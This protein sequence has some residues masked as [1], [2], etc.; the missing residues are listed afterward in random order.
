MCGCHNVAK[1]NHAAAN[2]R[3]SGRPTELGR[4]GRELGESTAIEVGKVRL[5]ADVGAGKF[6][7]LRYRAGLSSVELHACIRSPSRQSGSRP[8]R[9]SQHN[10]GGRHWVLYQVSFAKSWHAQGL[11]AAVKGKA[12]VL[13]AAGCGVEGE[14]RTLGGGMPPPKCPTHAAAGPVCIMAVHGPHPPPHTPSPPQPHPPFPHHL[15]PHRH[16]CPSLVPPHLHVHQRAARV[17]GDVRH[18]HGNQHDLQTAGPTGTPLPRLYKE[19]DS[20]GAAPARQQGR[21]RAC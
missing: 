3:C 5:K 21:H 7:I 14:G 10:H 8:R 18:H 2:R 1:T 17:K 15:S 13:R 16:L 19:G 20:T 9:G 4:A 12:N 6:S 11:E